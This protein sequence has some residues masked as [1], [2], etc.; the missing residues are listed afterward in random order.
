LAKHGMVVLVGRDSAKLNEVQKTIEK[1]GQRAVSV[2]CD[3]SEPASVRCAVADIIALHLPI[4][5]L[6]NNAGIRQI[7]AT[8][9]SLAGTRRL[10]QITSVPSR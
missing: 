7:R 6:L 9:N 4:V 5:G 1:N 10:R 8:T 2:V 3:L